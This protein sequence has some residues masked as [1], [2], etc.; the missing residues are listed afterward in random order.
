[1]T[2]FANPTGFVSLAKLVGKATIPDEFKWVLPLLDSVGGESGVMKTVGL[3]QFHASENQGE[4]IVS[5]TAEI[6]AQLKVEFGGLSIHF[7]PGTSTGTTGF[8]FS[9]TKTA[10]DI[11]V[12]LEKVSVDISLPKGFLQPAKKNSDGSYTAGGS[13]EQVKFKFDVNRILF[14]SKG[15]LGFEGFTIKSEQH[16]ALGDTGIFLVNVRVNLEITKNQSVIVTFP[17]TD[18]ILPKD[19]AASGLPNALKLTGGRIDDKGFSG[20]ISAV[21]A[22]PKSTKVL[23]FEGALGQ[24]SI[25]FADNRLIAALIQG[26]IVLPFFD[27]PKSP[28]SPLDV[29][30]N[31]D[32]AGNL[33]AGLRAKANQSIAS[34]DL[35]YFALQVSQLHIASGVKESMIT[36]SGAIVLD[37][38]SKTALKVAVQDLKISSTG[39]VYMQGGWYDVKHKLVYEHSGFKIQISRVGFGFGQGA[40]KESFVGLDGAVNLVGSLP[41]RASVTG[42]KFV[43]DERGNYGFKLS[44]ASAALAIKDVLVF[45]AG[46]EF[47]DE[48]NPPPIPGFNYSEFSGMMGKI[49]L[50]LLPLDLNLSAD[51]LVAKALID[52]KEKRFWF[53]VLRGDLPVGIPLGPSGIAIYGLQGLLAENMKPTRKPKTHWYRDWY[54]IQPIGVDHVDKWKPPEKGSALAIG[55]GTTLGTMADNGYTFNARAILVIAVPG[56]VVMLAGKGN[57]LTPRKNLSDPNAEALFNFLALFDGNEGTLL[58][59]LEVAYIQ[60]KLLEVRGLMEIFFDLNDADNWHFYLG[61]KPKEKRIQ[62]KLVDFLSANTYFMLDSRKID[63]G[64]YIGYGPKRWVF[65]PLTVQLAAYMKG[66][67]TISWRPQFFDAKLTMYGE[68]L[69]KLFWFQLGLLLEASVAVKTP[70]PYRVDIL[71][72]AKLK[73]PFPLPSPEV[74]IHLVFEDPVPPALVDPFESVQLDQHEALENSLTWQTR[75]KNSFPQD[76]E[77][78]PMDARLSAVFERRVGLKQPK[79]PAQSSSF[80]IGEKG[81]VYTFDYVIDDVKLQKLDG[82]Q[83]AD[84]TTGLKT[85]W[86]TQKV[87]NA[88]DKPE[89]SILQIGTTD[90]NRMWRHV[91]NLDLPRPALNQI[92]DFVCPPPVS[93]K[94]L[95]WQPADTSTPRLV[96]GGLDEKH[97]QLHCKGKCYQGKVQP[98]APIPPLA[99]P[100][101][102]PI[103]TT[104]GPLVVASPFSYGLLAGSQAEAEFD[105]KGIMAKI[106]LE[107]EYR[108]QLTMEILDDQDRPVDTQTMDAASHTTFRYKSKTSSR[109]NRIRLKGDCFTLLKLC[110][111]PLAD[112]QQADFVPQS[113]AFWEAAVESWGSGHLI[114]EPN[115]SYRLTVSLTGTRSGNGT[116]PAAEKYSHAAYFKTGGPPK[117]LS[118]YIERTMPGD[119]STLFYR[120][121]LVEV[122]FKPDCGYAI[123]MYQKAQENLVLNITDESGKPKEYQ[124]V[125]VSGAYLRLTRTQ[126]LFRREVKCLGTVFQQKEHKYKQTHLK[127]GKGIDRWTLEPETRYLATIESDKQSDPLYQFS[128]VS[129]RFKNFADLIKHGRTHWTLNQD[130]RRG[131][132]GEL[133]PAAKFKIEAGDWSKAV[134]IIRTYWKIKPVGFDLLPGGRNRKAESDHFDELVKL[135]N[136]PPYLQPKYTEVHQVLDAQRHYGFL[137]DFPEPVNWERVTIS[138]EIQRS[139]GKISYQWEKEAAVIRN[140]DGTR[141]FI[142]C[143]PQTK[144][145]QK[146]NPFHAWRLKK[147]IYEVLEID[148]P[149]PAKYGREVSLI[150]FIASLFSY[151]GKRLFGIPLTDVEV[152]TLSDH[153]LDLNFKVD[154]RFVLDFDDVRVQRTN[155]DKKGFFEKYPD[156]FTLHNKANQ[157]V[158][159]VDLEAKFNNK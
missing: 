107:V 155:L 34:L 98:C 24:V 10:A 15:N 128:F 124:P 71:A 153:E 26:Q 73:L 87:A 156:L 54:R 22:R 114:L 77:P 9:L 31:I 118:P 79:L 136:L 14:D 67:A 62:A 21:W 84:V 108:D 41:A 137:I 32:E 18:V 65:G 16:I 135:L 3:S 13:D 85:S 132:G 75:P 144:T 1:M 94:Y 70:T 143:M 11:K 66:E 12:G 19:L 121:Y 86:A 48:S 97:F 119:K 103:A 37:P 138:P 2:T 146:H 82:T 130:A 111:L 5:G 28:K 88:S 93:T 60:R 39:A 81:V 50:A 58:F 148:Q 72:R 151:V 157:T 116:A 47:F 68:L 139:D 152:I 131:I 55:I 112:A 80:Q 113:R 56:P 102:D 117:D 104:S 158:E 159:Q 109:I 141:V 64:F 92:A 36:L 40:D 154:C 110:Y 27:N 20:Q 38:G 126:E 145:I 30:V 133:H 83:W 8:Q 123:K 63:F 52:G 57:L 100:G 99:W 33:T 46:L 129:S 125:T 25:K 4:F 6:L 149:Q 115:S 127:F 29:L 51:L 61:E 17:S 142:A 101:E 95:C 147:P 44:G 35:G 76:Y 74:K 134:D 140:K 96:I 91:K 42:F 120:D 23:G 106:E 53:I 49:K 122:A 69:I 78:A 59:N 90:P 105:F 45:E 89:K 7:L 43:W 150:S